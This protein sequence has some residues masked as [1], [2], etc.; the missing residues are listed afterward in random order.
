MPYTYRIAVQVDQVELA[1]F[2]YATVPYA[3][4]VKGTHLYQD[5]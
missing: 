3:A 5:D 2:C 4:K 1:L